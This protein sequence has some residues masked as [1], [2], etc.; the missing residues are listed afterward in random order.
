MANVIEEK[1][2]VKPAIYNYWY[3]QIDESH[4]H[5]IE[6]RKP[7][8]KECLLYDTINMKFKNS[9]NCSMAIEVNIVASFRTGISWEEEW[10]SEILEIFYIFMWVV[11]S[12][13]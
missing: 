13:A 2:R 5:N 11:V 9:Q 12:F 7:N 4:R 8:V 10:G 3:I 1:E 6:W